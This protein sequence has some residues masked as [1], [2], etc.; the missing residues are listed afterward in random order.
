MTD[1][2][3]IKNE[4]NYL[5]PDKVY[6]IV[7]WVALIVLPALAV[8]VQ[9]IGGSANWSGTSTTV[10]VIT[11]LGVFIG[12]ILGVDSA[13]AH[14][15]SNYSSAALEVYAKMNA[16]MNAEKVQQAEETTETS[17]A[18]ETTEAP[19]AEETK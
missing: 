6:D 2:T 1:N 14:K 7:K 9:T 4:L 11:A 8:L 5:I 18:E 10:T 12:A 16:K 15:T 19:K 17:K 3:N 13:Q